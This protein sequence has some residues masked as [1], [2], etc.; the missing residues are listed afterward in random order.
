V[1]NW[2]RSA[3]ES[4]PH[5]E[6]PFA[7]EYRTTSLYFDTAKHD[8]FHRR[9][10]FGRAKYRI[11]RYS[12]HDFVFLE[13][14]LR[15]PGF[16]FKRRTRTPIGVLHQLE[17]TEADGPW[18]G[19]WFHRRLLAEGAWVV[20]A[21]G[22]FNP[23][24]LLATLEEHFGRLPGA[25]RG[26][27]PLPPP[28]EP[29]PRLVLVPKPLPQSTVVWARFGPARAAPDFYSL[30][31]ADHLLGAGGFQSRLVK[32]VRSNRGL[33]YSVASF[34]D[35][36][37]E[38]GVLGLQAATKKES[39][40]E[41]VS[42]LR[43]LAEQAAAEGFEAREV[44]EAK[45]ALANRHVFRYAD[46]GSAIQEVMSL[47][48]DGLPLD[49]PAAYLPRMLALTREQVAAAC[50]AYYRSGPGVTVVVGDVDPGDAAWKKRP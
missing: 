5:G 44:A 48:L 15:K 7:D 24:T 2:A 12:E 34:Y 46:P 4:D 43:D 20:G 17:R 18:L 30:E 16:L 45:E 38:F 28:P 26:F 22:D 33:A 8:V 40:A 32:E 39:T 31:L 41:V 1:R 42:L 21:V 9:G 36:Y 6:G 13:R 19:D 10:S 29:E 3:L 27:P 35:A 14:K 11:R 23:E 47:L 50:R 49:L 37:S 25:G